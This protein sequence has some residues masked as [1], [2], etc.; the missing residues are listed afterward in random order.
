MV[1][2]FQPLELRGKPPAL[3]AVTMATGS[4]YWQIHVLAGLS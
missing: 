2:G 1:S 3:P 4:V